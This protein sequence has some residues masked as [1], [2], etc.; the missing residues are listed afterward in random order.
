MFILKGKP[1]SLS[2]V[3]VNLENGPEKRKASEI[4]QKKTFFVKD[5]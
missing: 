5:G 4:S 3:L 1:M 2:D